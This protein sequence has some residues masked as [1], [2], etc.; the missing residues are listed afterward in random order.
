[1]KSDLD[2][3]L[4]HGTQGS[5]VFLQ[6]HGRPTVMPAFAPDKFDPFVWFL[7]VER[8][9]MRSDLDYIQ[10][11]C[12]LGSFIF[13]LLKHGNP[14]TLLAFFPNRLGLPDR[15]LA[16]LLDEFLLGATA[17]SRVAIGV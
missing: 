5:F 13:S 12:T 4:S 6:K 7:L 1:V 8:T 17:T 16:N 2:Y 15:V 3:I 11:R 14:T 10:S 9:H